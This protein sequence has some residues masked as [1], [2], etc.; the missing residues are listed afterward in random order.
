MLILSL[1]AGFWVSLMILV[2]PR[3]LAHPHAVALYEKRPYRRR[4]RASHR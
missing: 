4:P 1:V 3:V 2:L